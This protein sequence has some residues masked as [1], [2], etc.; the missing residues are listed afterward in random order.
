MIL[1]LFVDT[2]SSVGTTTR[3]F[4]V[5]SGGR[6]GSPGSVIYGKI[7]GSGEKPT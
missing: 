3:R 1:L 2:A 6:D 4:V 5:C 7:D